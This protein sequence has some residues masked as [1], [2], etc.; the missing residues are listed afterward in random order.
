MQAFKTS[1][2][3]SLQKGWDDQMIKALKVDMDKAESAW[4]YAWVSSL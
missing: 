4:M 2:P 3:K 1:T